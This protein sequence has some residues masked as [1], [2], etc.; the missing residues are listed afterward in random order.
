MSRLAKSMPESP[1]HSTPFSK[2][3][4]EASSREKKRVYAKVLEK[5]TNDQKDLMKKASAAWKLNG[6]LFL[7]PSSPSSIFSSFF[8][9]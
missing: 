4:R 7:A 1:K 6:K 3:I 2:F 5:A 8:Q 9:I